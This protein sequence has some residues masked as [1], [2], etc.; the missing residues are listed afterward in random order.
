MGFDPFN[1]KYLKDADDL[2]V[3]VHPDDREVIITLTN[4]DNEWMD[5][6]LS[7]K[8]AT[9]MVNLIMKGIAS[10]FEDEVCDDW[11]SELPEE[12]WGDE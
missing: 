11:L 5:V 10:R 6:K 3:T 7:Y 1:V 2:A 12:E 8:N 9:R 4:P